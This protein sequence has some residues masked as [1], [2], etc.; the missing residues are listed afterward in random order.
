MRI[1]EEVLDR[2][3][4][5]ADRAR[6]ELELE[7]REP[8]V[9]RRIR[10]ADLIYVGGGNTLKM[11][12]R[13]RHLGVDRLLQQARKQGTVLSGVSAGANCWFQY[14]SSDSMKFYR[15]RDWKFIRV[16]EGD[17]VEF[18]LDNH[19]NNKMPHNIDL[20]AVTGPGGGASSSLSAP[21]HSSV[22]SFKALNPG[23]YVYHCATAPVAMHV[24]NGM[25]GLILV[26]PKGG[27]P[28]VDREYYVM[29]GDF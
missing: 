10:Q 5:T 16:R 18:H 4:E 20:H 6:R 23:L 22:F 15:P 29:Q 28:K 12:R 2:V 7:R 11:M 19:P 1:V 25:Y 3:L 27:L 13:W 21:G 8:R 26:E 24:G 14:G 9:A 17:L